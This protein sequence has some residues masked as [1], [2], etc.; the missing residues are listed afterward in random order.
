MNKSGFA[1][2]L[3]NDIEQLKQK[4][5]TK[6]KNNIITKS[7]EYITENYDIRYDIISLKYEWK[8]KAEDIYREFNEND[9]FC[10][11]QEC[12]YEINHTKLLAIINSSW[13]KQHNPFK[14][15]FKNLREWDN[16]TDHIEKL[17]A[18]LDVE[19][20]EYFIKHFKK[21][22]VRVVACALIPAYFNKQMLLF[23]GEQNNG[24]T[25][26]QRFLCPNSLSK[27]L[28]EDLIQGKDELITLTQSFLIL[29]DELSKL[30][31]SGIEHV[32]QL[33]TKTSVNFRPPYGRANKTFFRYSSFMGNTNKAEFLKDETGSVRFLCFS[34]KQIDFKYSQVI[35][36]DDLYSQAYSLYENGFQYEVTKE[37]AI[38][39]QKYNM[40]FQVLT[41]EQE[42]I[43]KYFEPATKIELESEFLT[44]TEIA[45]KL[46]ICTTIK[47][48]PSK[49]GSGLKFLGFTRSAERK[50]NSSIPVYGYRIKKTIEFKKK[51]DAGYGVLHHTE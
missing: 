41:T 32:K 2:T 24:K 22:I 37:E 39:I 44:P 34:L 13:I 36:M 50:P 45:E 46:S 42:L 40:R 38:E 28:S 8:R 43:S 5:S 3:N 35:N 9:L 21:W 7:K 25:S 47:V 27:Y 18:Y 12:G 51:L 1:K 11:L 33:M 23:V 20:K 19:D 49:I 48:S 14:D 15:Y 31:K 4:T 16:K 30:D 6:K 29:M 26:L 10:E 17:A